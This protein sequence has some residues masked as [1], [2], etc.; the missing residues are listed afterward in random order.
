MAAQK[1][2]RQA[3]LELAAA[4]SDSERKH[5]PFGYSPDCPSAE[6][7]RRFVAGKS[8]R[9]DAIL[10]HLGTCVRC[11]QLLG[12]LRIRSV[13]VQRLA[14]A[15]AS[16]IAIVLLAWLIVVRPARVPSGMAI[17]DLRPP[18]APRG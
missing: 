8:L 1:Q 18:A 10:A 12:S 3:E 7:L 4:L 14:L 13:R 16:V 2:F 5:G 6:E 17:I 9:P 15:F 11:A